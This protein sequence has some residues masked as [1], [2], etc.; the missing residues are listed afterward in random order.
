MV[1]FLS[2]LCLLALLESTNSHHFDLTVMGKGGHRGGGHHSHSSSSSHHTPSGGGFN[3]GGYGY[4]YG[5]N[6]PYYGTNTVIV[7]RPVTYSNNNDYYRTNNYANNSPDGNSGCSCCSGGRCCKVMI[8]LLWGFVMLVAGAFLSGRRDI[9]MDTNE[10]RLY[11]TGNPFFNQMISITDD[12]ATISVYRVDALPTLVLAPLPTL[13][14][15]TV[16]LPAGDFLD[17]SYHLNEGSSIVVEFSSDIGVNMLLFQ[18]S[19]R[20]AQ[21]IDDPDA[22]EVNAKAVK[23]SSNKQQSIYKLA[24]GSPDDYVVVFDNF[25]DYALSNVDFVITI[26]RADYPLEGYIPVCH[27][28]IKCSVPLYIGDKSTFILKAPSMVATDSNAAV[29]DVSSKGE[30]SYNV[31]ISGESRWATISMI[32]FF[33]PVLI[34]FLVMSG[35]RV[36]G[37]TSFKPTTT[38]EAENASMQPLP[39]GYSPYSMDADNDS[40][41]SLLRDGGVVPAFATIDGTN[42]QGQ[43]HPQAMVSYPHTIPRTPTPMVSATLMS[44]PPSAPIL[45]NAKPLPF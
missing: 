44:P 28:Q 36:D 5:Y 34:C 35:G 43:Y 41:V 19:D 3:R 42:A 31:H 27:A 2:S 21:W 30:M 24:I 26:T 9:I 11:G 10:T 23:F 14:S 8:V 13:L 16:T 1:T 38:T 22:Y 12:T 39:P 25:N 33:L 18:G 37:L 6:R 40:A 17:F 45:P 29:L 20:L 15:E 7:N 4:G 32:F